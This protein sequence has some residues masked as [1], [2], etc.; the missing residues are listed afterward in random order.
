MNEVLNCTKSEIYDLIFHM[1]K[2]FD[3]VRL[4]D[5]ISMTVYTMVDDKILSEPYKCYRVWKKQ[6]RCENC[7]S[8][9]LPTLTDVRH[10]V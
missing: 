9:N 2:I 4:V 5:P 7:I 6:D 10:H 8:V 1:S 3:I